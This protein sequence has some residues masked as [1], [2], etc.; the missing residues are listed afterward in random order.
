MPEL[1]QANLAEIGITLTIEQRRPG[2]LHAAL[3][4]GDTPAEERPNFMTLGLVA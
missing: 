1:F 3:F 4:Y 2:D